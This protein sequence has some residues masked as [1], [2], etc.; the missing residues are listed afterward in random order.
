MSRNF[1]NNRSTSEVMSDQGAECP[2]ENELLARVAGTLS[3]ARVLAI[4]AHI[5]QCQNCRMVLAEAARGSDEIGLRPLSL[6]TFAPN[7]S[8]AG[9]YVIKRRLA[10]GGMGE[11]YEAHDTWLDELIAIKTVVPTIADNELA[12]ARLKAEMRLARRVTHKNVCRVYDLGF[13]RR[14]REQIAFLTME[15]VRGTTLRRRFEDQGPFDTN[16]LIPIVEQIV[17]A[18]GHAHAEGIVHRDLKPDNVMLVGNGDGTPDRAVVMDFGLARM[19]LVADTQPLTP[20]SHTV[21]GTLDYMSPEQVQGKHAG[22]ASDIY[23]LGVMLY[24]LL[25][26]R[27][28]FEGESPLARALLRVTGRPPSLGDALPDADPAWGECIARC[29]EP[30]PKDRFESIGEIVEALPGAPHDGARA[31]ST[32]TKRRMGL[33]AVVGVG[34]AAALALLAHTPDRSSSTEAAKTLEPV[35]AGTTTVGTTPAEV[36]PRA[37]S[38]VALTPPPADVPGSPLASMPSLPK[39]LTLHRKNRSTD[40]PVAAPPMNDE[41]DA[42]PRVAETKASGVSTSAFHEAGQPA[43]APGNALINP[44][45]ASR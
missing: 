12:L 7:E 1:E 22:P 28:P 26:G 37:A 16:T 45:A 5:D 39:R 43:P 30:D 35:A 34:A 13:H 3:A 42:N 10:A 4:D 9:R 14:G 33:A 27:L 19:A 32:R 15:L 20:N 17:A 31:R 44:F 24:E 2:S 25:T 41:P 38:P 23:S 29:L 8:V 40:P 6:A 18:L 36:P 11:V 21:L